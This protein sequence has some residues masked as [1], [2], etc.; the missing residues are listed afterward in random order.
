MRRSVASC[1]R[2]DDAELTRL[3]TLPPRKYGI[4]HDAG[5]TA[6]TRREPRRVESIR[7]DDL[8]T[9]IAVCVLTYLRPVGLE[10][11]L[12]ELD[13]L[14]VP[15]DVE[16]RVFVVDNDPERSAEAAAEAH[17]RSSPFAVSYV[18]EPTR[19]ISSGRNASIDAARAWGADALCFIDDDEWPEPDWLVELLATARRTGAD[20]VTGPVFPA[21]DEP[22][23]SWIAEGGYF[24]RPRHD[25][26]GLID[27]ATTSSVLID[28]HCFDGRSEPF[29]V[30]FGLSG[31]SDTH[32]FAELHDAGG[33]IA[34][35]DRAH[36]H[37]AIPSSRVSASWLLRREYRRGQTMSR[38]LRRRDPRL[39]RYVR[40]VANATIQ[41]MSGVV[42]L[43]AGLPFGRARWFRGA[44]M[45][46][47]GAGMVTGL[48]SSGYQEYRRIH[49]A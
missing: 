11:V 34:W 13:R 18:H 39:V 12:R 41:V 23:P 38:S 22:P 29:D 7:R 44:K 16:I 49:G 24:E 21:F 37:E 19:G 40:R 43:V 45:I 4:S 32:F 10:R 25:H 5:G 47:L 3:P 6:R 26:D 35:C 28:M 31:G 30:E 36:V 15:D 48:V 20:V 1:P 17:A 8:L 14:L 2:R 33:R 46:V 9:R 42:V 27:Y